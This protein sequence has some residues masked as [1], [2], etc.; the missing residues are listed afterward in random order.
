MTDQ[1]LNV[2]VEASRANWYA[3]AAELGITTAGTQVPV[4]DT[5]AAL[6]P[7]TDWAANEDRAAELARQPDQAAHYTDADTDVA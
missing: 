4:A 6:N 1:E 5:W 2:R 3:R 7:G